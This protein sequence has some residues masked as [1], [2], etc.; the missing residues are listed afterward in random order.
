[1]QEEDESKV[2]KKSER[3]EM[4]VQSTDESVD[5]YISKDIPLLRVFNAPPRYVDQGGS[6]RKCALYIP[7]EP[8]DCSDILDFVRNNDSK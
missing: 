6:K 7:E 2:N 4:I 3:S 8:W 1:M 5:S